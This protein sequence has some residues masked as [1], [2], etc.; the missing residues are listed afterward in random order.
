MLDTDFRGHQSACI[1]MDQ[2]AQG[3]A[4]GGELFAGRAALHHWCGSAIVDRERSER[5]G[6]L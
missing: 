3:D 6:T 4:G 5:H 1:V 2:G